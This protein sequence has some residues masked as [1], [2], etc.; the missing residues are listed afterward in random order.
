MNLDQFLT[1]PMQ[2]R[3]KV[4]TPTE[5]RSTQ[6]VALNQVASAFNELTVSES[7]NRQYL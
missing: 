5:L 3:A 7:I 1:L 4:V 2:P 6:H